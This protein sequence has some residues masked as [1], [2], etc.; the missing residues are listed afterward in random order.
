[1]L[2]CC[3][4]DAGELKD[5]FKCRLHVWSESFGILGFS[6]MGSRK[7]ELWAPAFSVRWLSVISLA[8][9]LKRFKGLSFS[10]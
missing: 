8:K 7:E 3:L 6:G 10:V 4:V 1:M 5:S 9:T 2:S